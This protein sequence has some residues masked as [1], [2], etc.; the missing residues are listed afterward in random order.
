MGT[1]PKTIHFSTKQK[2]STALMLGNFAA[3]LV[4]V[5]NFLQTID[6]SIFL[7]QKSTEIHNGG[8]YLNSEDR[9]EDTSLHTAAVEW[10]EWW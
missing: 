3:S 1:V 2:M 7:I 8:R 4:I 6:A 9:N 5:S 10:T